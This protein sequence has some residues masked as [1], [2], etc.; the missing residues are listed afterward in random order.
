MIPSAT[1]HKLLPFTLILASTIAVLPGNFNNSP[2]LTSYD[3]PGPRSNCYIKV[4]DPHISE[5]FRKRGE[6]WVKVNAK[7]FCT[8]SHSNVRLTIE[9]WKEGRAGSN[10]VGKFETNPNLRSS[11]GIDVRLKSASVKCKNAKGTNYYAY[12][13]GKALVNGKQ[14][15]TP[16]AVSK[17]V[18]L[19]CGT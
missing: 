15:R 4:D 3:E 9:I 5:H 19:A 18:T 12:A 6:D 7:S 1:P 10:F 13:Y 17:I 16:V 14:R 11:S 8:Q 2:N